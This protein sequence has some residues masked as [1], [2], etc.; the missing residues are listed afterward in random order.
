MASERGLVISRPVEVSNNTLQ[1]MGSVDLQELRLS[2]LFWDKLDYPT[3]NLIHFG[4]D[5][6]C[7]FL[8]G[9]GVLRR[10]DIRVI[11]SGQMAQ[12]F[13]QAH[14]AAFKLLDAKEPGVWSVAT[15]VNAVSFPEADLDLGRGV[16][17]SLHRAI[18]VPDKEVPLQDV[19]EFRAK[20]RD[21]LMALRHHLEDI[22]ERVISAADGALALAKETERLQRA[23]DN[24]IK[25]ARET[26]FRLRLADVDASLNF[27][28][29]VGVGAITLLASGSVTHAL[30]AAAGSAVLSVKVGPSLKSHKATATPFRYVS[31][32]HRE[33]FP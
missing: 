26:R 19:L 2:L 6:E 21:E 14:V 15:G 33:L 29:A 4:L 23:V 11:G 5:P 17:V 28:P 27:A 20:R 16:L 7:Q 13:V 22:Y 18:P 25:I 8:E 32:Y 12:A 24:H 30:A 10:T 9:A 31:S 3:N 1:V